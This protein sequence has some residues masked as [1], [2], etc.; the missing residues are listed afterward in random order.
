MIKLKPTAFAIRRPNICNVDKEE[1]LAFD[2]SE[3]KDE[4]RNRQS[5]D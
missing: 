2:D 5:G 4:E 3:L 1:S